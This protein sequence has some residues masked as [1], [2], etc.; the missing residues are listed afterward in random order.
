MWGATGTA[1]GGR[2]QLNGAAVEGS[3]QCSSEVRGGYPQKAH[4]A[5]GG[6]ESHLHSAAGCGEGMPA[7]AHRAALGW[8]RG[9]CSVAQWLMAHLVLPA[10]DVAPTGMVSVD[11]EIGQPW[12]KPSK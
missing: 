12:L 2:S 1:W 7:Q 9:V 8:R 11:L 6:W 4:I 5:V 10:Q 3:T